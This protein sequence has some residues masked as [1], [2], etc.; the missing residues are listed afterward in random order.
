MSQ[1]MKVWLILSQTGR[2]I[3]DFLG[4]T[5]VISAVWYILA[6]V[7][8][9]FFANVA[10]LS[11]NLVSVFIP[12]L[13]LLFWS[14]PLTAAAYS[15]TASL[16][17]KEE[18]WLRDIFSRLRP[19]YKKSVGAIAISLVILGIL[20]VDVIFFSGAE[21]ALLRWLAVFWYYLIAF[22]FLALQY[23]FPLMVQMQDGVWKTLKKA[24]LVAMDN[25]IVSVSLFV[26]GVLFVYLS[27]FTYLPF[28]L[29]FMGCLSTLHNL[30][31]VEILKKY[32]DPPAEVA[33]GTLE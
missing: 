6:F 15:M 5:I 4:I 12:L 7:P 17:D 20:V 22:W 16:M 3:Y 8:I 13:I 19:Y 27:V 9:F 21:S 11:P 30:A 1:L 23:L 32:D 14:T 31:L 25:V 33:E 18:V 29:L 24:V 28:V 2:Q 10:A 26:V